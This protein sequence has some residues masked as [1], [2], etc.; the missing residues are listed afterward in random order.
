MLSK[1]AL[2]IYETRRGLRWAMSPWSPYDL[3]F[4][5]YDEV[6]RSHDEQIR[7]Y[8]D[9]FRWRLVRPENI[10]TLTCYSVPLHEATQYPYML[11][12]S[13]KQHNNKIQNS[14][15]ATSYHTYNSKTLQPSL[16]RSL[17]LGF[18]KKKKKKKKYKAVTT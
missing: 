4:R 11:C 15:A 8:D 13:L 2:I 18:V 5:S 1:L 7:S 6:F 16:L 10:T 3:F 14:R 9:G 12:T 17:V